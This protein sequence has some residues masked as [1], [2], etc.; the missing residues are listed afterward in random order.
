LQDCLGE[1]NDITVNKRFATQLAAVG[2]HGR[3]RDIQSSRRF[4]AGRLHG[5][6]EAST[7]AGMRSAKQAYRQFARAKP[8]WN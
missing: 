7:G 8:F 2:G 5:R 1:L 6:E 4:A 3:K